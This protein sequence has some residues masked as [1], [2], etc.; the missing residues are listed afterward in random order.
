MIKKLYIAGPMTG[1]P[2]YN[3]P[4]F[5]SAEY[6]LRDMGYEVENPTVNDGKLKVMG[7]PDPSWRDYMRASI[8]QVLEVDGICALD[9]WQWSPGARLEVDIAMALKLPIRTL[10][11]WV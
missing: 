2:E 9:G 7:N 3:Y 5:K 1:Y 6:I 11:Q 10:D 8:A 4:A